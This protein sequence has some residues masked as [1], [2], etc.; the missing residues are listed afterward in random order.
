VLGG[1]QVVARMLES[2]WVLLMARWAVACAPARV[3]DLLTRPCRTVSGGRPDASCD[4]QQAVMQAPIA[5]SIAE[6]GL[7]ELA[8][9]DRMMSSWADCVAY[10]A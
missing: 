7:G 8:G 5:F 1:Y 10:M 6:L 3:S 2:Y 4:H 9:A